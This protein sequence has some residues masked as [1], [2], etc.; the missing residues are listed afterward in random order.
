MRSRTSCSQNIM[1]RHKHTVHSI[2]VHN[3]KIKGQVIRHKFKHR[4][5]H[6]ETHNKHT[7][8]TR[9]KARARLRP[10]GAWAPG[11]S[12]TP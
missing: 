8:F 11:I 9:G 3:T 5:S 4:S 10:P 2:I 6:T 1:S 12:H 7:R